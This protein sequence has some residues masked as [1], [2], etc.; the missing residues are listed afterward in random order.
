MDKIDL[1]KKYRTI[2]GDKVEIFKIDMVAQYPVLAVIT[3]QSGTQATMTYTEDG[4]IHTSQHYCNDNLIEI[5]PY[6]DFKI[7]EPVM[8]RANNT[9]CW[10]RR[11]FAGVAPNGKAKIWD[12][13]RTTWTAEANGLIG[14]DFIWSA[15]SQCRRP[16]PEELA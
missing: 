2:G 16:T 10:Q 14:D 15:W 11:H 13:G 9:S 5:P 4:F 3:R 6:E 7:D 8:V 12:G 1:N